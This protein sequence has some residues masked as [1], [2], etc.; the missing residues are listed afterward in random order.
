MFL[1]VGVDYLPLLPLAHGHVSR[2]PQHH[3]LA[4][5]VALHRLVH[6]HADGHVLRHGVQQNA[7]PVWA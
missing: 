5:V 6:G 7:D 3:V 2:L 1:P 4:A